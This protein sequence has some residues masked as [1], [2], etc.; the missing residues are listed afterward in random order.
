MSP[1]LCPK[2]QLEWIQNKL[3]I[4]IIGHIPSVSELKRILKQFVDINMC[5]MYKTTVFAS[6]RDLNKPFCI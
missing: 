2:I 1:Y 3:S 4:H 5:K 6:F